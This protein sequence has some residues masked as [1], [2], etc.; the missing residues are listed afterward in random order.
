MISKTTLSFWEGYWSL[1]K[2]IQ[3]K[4]R[5]SYKMWRD[6]PA[7]PSLHFK[8]VKDNKPVY[9][10]RVTLDYRAIGLLEEDTVTWFWIGKHSDYD[11][12]L[13]KL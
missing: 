6:N 9:S 5:A 1:P 11:K 8:R 7:H 3:K 2:E 10:V 13:S 4:A 12:F